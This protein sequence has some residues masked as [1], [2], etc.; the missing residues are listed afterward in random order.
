MSNLNDI[1]N[2]NDATGLQRLSDSQDQGVNGR[3]SEEPSQPVRQFNIGRD[4]SLQVI[5][6]E[7]NAENETTVDQGLD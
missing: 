6:E 3:E 7:S 2:I 4:E 1:S 5:Q